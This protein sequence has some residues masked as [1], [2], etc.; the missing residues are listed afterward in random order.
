MLF[1]ILEHDSQNYTYCNVFMQYFTLENINDLQD[2]Q[3][4]WSPSN[5]TQEGY[6]IDDNI[7]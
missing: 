5:L 2:L 1:K 6:Y 7:L 3:K 4:K